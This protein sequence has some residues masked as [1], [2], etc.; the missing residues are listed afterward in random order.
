[1]FKVNMLRLINF[2]NCA[3][4]LEQYFLKK[5]PM[6]KIISLL[7]TAL[8]SLTVLGVSAFADEGSSEN[9]SKKEKA[10]N[11]TIDFACVG[12]AVDV[13]ETAIIAGFT[14]YNTSALSALNTRKTALAAAWKLTTNEEVRKAVK[15]AMSA[16]KKSLKEARKVFKDA[17]KSAW[18]SYKTSAKACNGEGE[19]LDSSNSGADATL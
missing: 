16:Y 13:R 3:T 4:I 17:R 11:A 10:E 19:K 6:K 9:E 15:A 5:S 8:F 12:A 18:D 2:K 1:M 14:T 7:L